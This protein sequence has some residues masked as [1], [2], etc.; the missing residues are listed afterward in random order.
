MGLALL[1]VATSSVACGS[2]TEPDWLVLTHVK[3]IRSGQPFHIFYA[4]DVEH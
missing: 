4:D 2:G 3:P 1:S